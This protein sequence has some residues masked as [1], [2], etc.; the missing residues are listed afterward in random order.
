M[1]HFIKHFVR[2]AHGWRCIEP[3]T[4]DLPEGRVQVNPG[5]VFTRGTRFMN[6]DIAELLDRQYATYGQRP[7]HPD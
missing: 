6:V 3:A 2:E 4:L 5:T 1:Q 7:Q